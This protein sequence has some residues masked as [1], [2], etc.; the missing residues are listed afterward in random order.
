MEMG[1]VRNEEWNW[2]FAV[3]QSCHEKYRIFAILKMQFYN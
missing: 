2:M 1:K 3:A